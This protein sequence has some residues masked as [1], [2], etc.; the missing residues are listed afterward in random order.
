MTNPKRNFA[1]LSLILLC[2]GLAQ[3]SYADQIVVPNA[4]TNT[5]G[6]DGIATTSLVRIQQVFASSQF[7]AAGGPIIITQIAL[8]PDVGNAFGFTFTNPNL[9]VNLSTTSMT[10]DGLSATFASNVGSDDTVVRN[11]PITLSSA[12]TGPPGGPKDFD[13]IITFTTPFLYDPAWGNLLIDLRSTGLL[14]P[15]FLDTQNTVGD[16]VSTLAGNIISPTGNGSSFGLVTQFTFT[17]T[18]RDPVPEPTTLLLLG[19][20][21]VGIAAKLRRNRKPRNRVEE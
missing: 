14:T 9:Q 15:A 1:S 21:L 10:P 16:S 7:A 6:N 3:T 8:R 5:E 17:P 4:N 12:N 2:L 13:I 18:A 11:G 20:G 19:S